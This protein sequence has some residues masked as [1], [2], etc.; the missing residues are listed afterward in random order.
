MGFVIYGDIHGCLDEFKELRK[1]VPQNQ[2]EVCVGDLI[3]RGEYDKE[4]LDYVEKN[5]IISVLGNHEYKHLRKY[6]GN[7]VQLDENQKF[8]NKQLTKQNFE[9]ISK[10]PFFIKD[11]NLTILHAGINN[12]FDLSKDNLSLILFFRE[13]DEDGNFLNLIHDNPN[14]RY[15]AEIYDGSNGFIVNGHQPFSD[16]TKF[17]NSVAIDTGCVYGNKLSA[18][19]IKDTTKPWE[20]E[21]FSVPS[22]K[23]YVEY[24]KPL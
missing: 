6:K 21:V 11:N 3:D 18:I 2:T 5:N 9:F 16:V 12:S 20:Y 8:V 22:K 23:Q 24:Y 1:I 13:V 4:V 10:M 17:P 7:K 14:A 15:W 19:Y